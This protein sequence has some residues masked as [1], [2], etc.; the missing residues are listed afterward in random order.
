MSRVSQSRCRHSAVIPA[1]MCLASLPACIEGTGEPGVPTRVAVEELRIGNFEG[2]DEYLF[3]RV[4]GIAVDELGR[5]FVA[6][7]LAHTIRA[8]GE[9][10][11]YLFTV[12]R[13]GSGPNE[14]SQPCCLAIGP[15]GLLWV[16]DSGNSRY[17]GFELGDQRAA[18]VH[19]LRMNHGDVYRHVRTTFTDLGRLIDIGMAVDPAVGEPRTTL[20]H[21]GP[22]GD[23]ERALAAPLPP[24][25]DGLVHRVS[26]RDGDR[27]AVLFFYQPFGPRHLTAYG[28]G[29]I[30]ADA[31]SSTYE[32]RLY[33]PDGGLEKVITRAG[34]RGPPL[35]P[36]QRARAD[37]M[38][39]ADGRRAGTGMPFST[40]ERH[41]VLAGL[42]FDEKG[43]L[44]VV[45]TALPGQP[46]QVDVYDGD[47]GFVERIVYPAG[48]QLTYAA[49]SDT[50]I[51]GVIRD[52]MDVPYVVRLR[53]E[54]GD[55]AP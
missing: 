1:L 13:R 7:F 19:T 6:D 9:D 47:G 37:S 26:M 43:R 41:P 29:G 55:L 25:P 27:S 30:H 23:L 40:P 48:L 20:F 4:S 17:V 21:V 54:A 28:P 33:S 36:E 5:I 11:S 8:F 38:I 51:V 34:E 24:D 42:E 46:R 3:G 22:R 35:T 50:I 53:L 44:W 15:D 39:A 32:V 49:L 12:A 45:R 10:G 14:V 16:R 18:G 52:E 2:R 31:V